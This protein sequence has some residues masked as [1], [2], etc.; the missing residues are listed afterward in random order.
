MSR[1]S[2]LS[3]SIMRATSININ[4]GIYG[5]LNNL[6]YHLQSH[7]CLNILSFIGFFPSAICQNENEI[8]DTHNNI[9]FQK[10][11]NSCQYPIL[12][13]KFILKKKTKFKKIYTILKIYN[14]F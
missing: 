12:Y 2:C 3:F 1:F 4:N 9:L 11:K 10:S 5:K 13:A 14:I 8:S 6:S 7:P